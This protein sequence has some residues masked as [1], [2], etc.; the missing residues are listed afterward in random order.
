MGPSKG[1]HLI[2][3]FDSLFPRLVDDGYQITSPATN[4]YNCLA[5]AVGENGRWWEPDPNDIYYWPPGIIREWTL[6]ALVLAYGSLG[7]EKCDDSNFKPD[8]EKI[9]IYCREGEPTHAARQVGENRWTSKLGVG[10]DIEHT[11]SGLEGETYGHVT[12]ILRRRIS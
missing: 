11:L 10:E 4:G 5:W 1:D 3:W 9:A 2:V 6:E 8:F 12:Q 7:F